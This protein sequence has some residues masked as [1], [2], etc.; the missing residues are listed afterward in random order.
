M[1][2]IKIYSMPISQPARAVSWACA[3][4]KTEVE[5]IFAMP[6]KD[7]KSPEYRSRHSIA[8]IPQLDDNGYILS[9]SH[10]IMCYLGDKFNWSLYPKDPKVRGRV[11]E[12]MNWHHSNARKITF[13]LF[14]PIFRPDLLA[15]PDVPALF[16]KELLQDNSHVPQTSGVLPT[17][18]RMLSQQKWLCG[19]VPTVADLSLYCEIGQCLDKFLGLFSAAKIDINSYPKIKA[20]CEE[21]EKLPGFQS[22]HKALA[23]F[24][25][26]VKKQV[27]EFKTQSK[28]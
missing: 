1:A 18:E 23:D 13:A 25:P 14:C 28:L 11:H 2:P 7:N 5:E 4:E 12:Y 6:G 21:C 19:D 3:Y 8:T 20:W 26:T 9:E 27:D 10:A 15:S 17:I 16:K 24:C 22:S